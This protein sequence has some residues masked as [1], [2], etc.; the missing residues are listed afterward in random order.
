MD[1]FVQQLINGLT[2]G[3]IYALIALGYTM[4]YGILRLINFAH[5]DVYM[6]G[7][8]AGFML[9]TYLGFAASPSIFGFIVVLFGSMIIAALIGMAIERFAY[10]PVR[11]YSRMTTLITAIGM[12]LLIEYLFVFI[13]SGTPRSFPSLLPNDNFTLFGNATISTSQMLIFAVSILLMIGLQWIIFKTKIGKAMRAVSFNLNSAKL[14]GVNTDFVIAFTF[15]LG[16]AL[17]A[18][19]GVLTAQYNPKIE[20]LMGIITGLKAFVAAVLGGIGNIPGAVLGGLLI[21]A[22][23]T[24]VV[25]YGSAIGI[26]ST[27]RDAVAFAILILVLLVRPAGLLGTNVQ[28]K[29]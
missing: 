11:K 12:S 27:Y 20:P 5:G 10:R 22:A 7:A 16:S 21:G 19:G 8:Y 1:T 25:G 17:A 26:P 14:M 29:V 3:S 15:A 6:I 18:A 24:L 28:E 2:I 23:E 9:A 4:V 13:F